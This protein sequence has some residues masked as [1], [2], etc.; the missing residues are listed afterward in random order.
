MFNKHASE[1]AEVGSLNIGKNIAALR[2]EKNMTQEDLAGALG[3]SARR[4]PSGKM[5]IPARTFRCLP[6]LPI[7]SA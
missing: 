5:K 7:C 3:V 6:K 1:K 2:K 4:F